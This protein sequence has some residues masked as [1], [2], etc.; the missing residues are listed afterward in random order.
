LVSMHYWIMGQRR[1]RVQCHTLSQRPHTLPLS[2]T[3][4]WALRCWSFEIQDVLC[5]QHAPRMQVETDKQTTR[6]HQTYWAHWVCLEREVKKVPGGTA[7]AIW[8]FLWI[9][10]VWEFASCGQD[11]HWLHTG[12]DS[13]FKLEIWGVKI[14]SRSSLPSVFNTTTSLTSN[15]MASKFPEQLHK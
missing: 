5:L 12:C 8:G 7:L 2:A 1:E 14:T 3:N 9:V 10:P 4:E 15:L 6:C 11:W 13:S